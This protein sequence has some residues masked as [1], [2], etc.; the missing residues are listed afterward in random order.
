MRKSSLCLYDRTTCKQIASHV[1]AT[2]AQ[3]LPSISD[4]AM[5]PHLGAVL[6]CQ[7]PGERMLQMAS[8]GCNT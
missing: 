8:F 6:M 4:I 2:G 3:V 7:L 5:L 1:R